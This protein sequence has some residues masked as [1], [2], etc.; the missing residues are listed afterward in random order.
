MGLTANNRMEASQ[1]PLSVEVNLMAH[2]GMSSLAL[3]G[4][5]RSLTGGVNR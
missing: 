4:A 1:L 2:T 5:A 3:T